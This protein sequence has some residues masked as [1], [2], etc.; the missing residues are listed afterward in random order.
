MTLALTRFGRSSGF[1]SSYF[2][3]FPPKGS[4]KPAISSGL[5][6]RGRTGLSPDFPTPKRLY[7]FLLPAI[8][9]FETGKINFD[10]N[11]QIFSKNKSMKLFR[12]F[13]SFTP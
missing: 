7:Y 6:R 10:H 5:Q 2:R 9:T 4:G 11:I 13:L 1:P 12:Q 8:L 3:A